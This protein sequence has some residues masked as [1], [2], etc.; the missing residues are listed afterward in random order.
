M[1][2]KLTIL[3][4][5]VGNAFCF[6]QNNNIN[7]RSIAFTISEKDL[8]PENI[9][10]DSKTE[11]FF[12]GSTRKGKIIKIDKSGNRTDFVNSKQDGLWMVIGMKVDSKNRLLWVCS[13]GGENLVGYNQKDDVEGRPAGIFKFDLNTGKLIKKYTLDRYGEVHFFNDLIVANNGDVYVTHMFED[14]AIY[15]IPKDKDELELFVKNSEIKYPNGIAIADNQSI[16]FVAHSQGIARI[17][18]KDKK[19]T[20]LKVPDGE[21]IS[22]RESIDGLYYYKWSLIGV[23]PDIK[24]VSRFFL[25][26]SGDGIKKVELLEKNHPMMNNPTTGVL[27]D[28]NFYYIANAQFGSFNEDGTLF[29]MEKLYEPTILKVKI[30]NNSKN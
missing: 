28:D 5:L 3:F 4:I 7:Q 21:K 26:E 29:P 8:I 12:V 9:A 1:V 27:I 14:S 22:E 18:I 10:F 15:K 23:H 16:L 17:D 6:S 13:S 19:I 25:N 20:N 30:N 11:S 2:R 24:K